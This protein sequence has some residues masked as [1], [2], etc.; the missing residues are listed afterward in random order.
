MCGVDSGV[1]TLVDLSDMAPANL[2]DMVVDDL[3]RAYV[4]SQ[5]REGGVIVRVN[6][7]DT[8]TVVALRGAG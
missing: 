7:D 3:G 8:A 5:A 1:T 4:G 2:G 6:P